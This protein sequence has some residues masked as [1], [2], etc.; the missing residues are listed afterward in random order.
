MSRTNNLLLLL[1]ALIV[2]A[3][4]LLPGLGGKFEGSDAQ[5]EALL[6]EQGHEPWFKPLW[7]PPSG[8]VE[9]LLFTLQAAAGAGIFGFVLGRRTGEKKKND[10]PR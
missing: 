3:P 7:E 9:S 6:K 1:A 8:E 5:A 4:L 2:A 10:D